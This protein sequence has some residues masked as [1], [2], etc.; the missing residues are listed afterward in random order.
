MN[1][2]VVLIIAGAIYLLPSLIAIWRWRKVKWYNVPA[3]IILNVLMGWLFGVGWFFA[4]WI[5]TGPRTYRENLA[6][7]AYMGHPEF[8]QIEANDA[9]IE[10]GER[11]REGWR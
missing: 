4:M 7:A 2:T 11:S 1:W 10:M 9:I 8:Q 3:V 5:A 6:M